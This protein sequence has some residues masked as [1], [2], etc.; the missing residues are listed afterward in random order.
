MNGF[1]QTTVVG[2]YIPLSFPIPYGWWQRRTRRLHLPYLWHLPSTSG[3]QTLKC[4]KKSPD[5]SSTCTRIGV[6]NSTLAKLHPSLSLKWSQLP[7]PLCPAAALLWD[8]AQ[9]N[10]RKSSSSFFFQSSSSDSKRKSRLSPILPGC[11]HI[12][13]GELKRFSHTINWQQVTHFHLTAAGLLAK[14]PFPQGLTTVRRARSGPRWLWCSNL[15]PF[16]LA[17][18]M[19]QDKNIGKEPLTLVELCELLR[20]TNAELR[21]IANYIYENFYKELKGEMTRWCRQAW[22]PEFHAQDRYGGRKKLTVHRCTTQPLPQ[23]NKYKREYKNLK[24]K[25]LMKIFYPQI[26]RLTSCGQ[27]T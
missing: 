6:F 17:V 1:H 27:I 3:L 5:I 7:Q 16:A 10:T 15:K 11:K 22:W 4:R 8:S 20:K 23:A 12:S 25:V 26:T 21:V 19:S 2:W 24:L 9:Q 14:H 18:E 13:F